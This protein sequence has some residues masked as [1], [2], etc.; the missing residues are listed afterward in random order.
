M[1]VERV[2]DIAKCPFLETQR[3][4]MSNPIAL[5][6]VSDLLLAPTATTV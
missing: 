1:S 5:Y 4:T 3:G 2:G 6:S